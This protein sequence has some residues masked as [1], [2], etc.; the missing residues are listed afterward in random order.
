MIASCALDG[1]KR[2]NNL[3]AQVIGAFTGNTF[4]RIIVAF[5]GGVDSAALL[6]ILSNSGFKNQLHA[7]HIN[8][9][10]QVDADDWQQHC[11]DFAAQL[12]VSF[13]AIKLDTKPGRGESVEAWA[14]DERYY[15]LSQLCGDKECVVTGHHID[16]LAETLLINLVRG[17][18]VHGLAAMPVKREFGRGMLLRPLRVASRDSLVDYAEQQGLGW[19]DDPS[20]ADMRFDRNFIRH[21]IMPLLKERWPKVTDNMA[22]A[23]AHCATAAEHLDQYAQAVLNGAG[24]QHNK[25]F[26]SGILRLDS[27]SRYLVLRRFIM[28]QGGQAPSMQHLRQIEIDVLGAKEDADPVFQLGHGA[29][30]RRYRKMLYYFPHNP[31][32]E[33]VA[34]DIKWQGSRPL[35]VPDWPELITRESLTE[36]GLNVDDIDWAEVSLRSRR[37][38]EVCRPRG[39]GHAKPLKYCLQK[40]AVPPWERNRPVVYLGD[41]IIAVVGVFVCEVPSP[42]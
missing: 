6:H 3:I 4:K 11:A 40:F 29:V 42:L 34:Y 10:L 23:S 1:S 32:F 14:R 30:L 16:D 36:L 26:V 13:Q 8:H 22:R 2:L 35:D 31:E 28:S 5:S 33:P 12:D 9:G 37:G 38:G 24:V 15:H 25:V 7:V 41:E 17:S 39:W 21:K 27:Q 20:N 18:G 19:V